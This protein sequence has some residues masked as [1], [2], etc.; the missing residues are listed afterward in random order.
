MLQPHCSAQEQ[1][2]APYYLQKGQANW[3]EAWS[4]PVLFH[5]GHFIEAQS[6]LSISVLFMVP[7][8]LPGE[9]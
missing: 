8:G 2:T 9:S 4:S 1:S 7:A 6:H 5:K 3:P